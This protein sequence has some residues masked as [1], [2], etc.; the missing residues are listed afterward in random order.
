M[1]RYGGA[2]FSAGAT[3]RRARH[4]D[5]LTIT[6][7]QKWAHRDDS[8]NRLTRLAT[9]PSLAAAARAGIANPPLR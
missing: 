4:R 3:W 1:G 2:D 9:S 6:G 8:G 7:L 5:T